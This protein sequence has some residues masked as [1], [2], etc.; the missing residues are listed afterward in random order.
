MTEKEQNY[1]YI[2][3]CADCFSH[4]FLYRKICAESY[5]EAHMEDSH[6]VDFSCT[7]GSRGCGVSSEV[8]TAWRF[9]A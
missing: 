1:A 2:F 7:G 3:N 9:A 5:C 6:L 4:S 8:G